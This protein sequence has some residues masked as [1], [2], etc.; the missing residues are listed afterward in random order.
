MS[1]F[2]LFSKRLTLYLQNAFIVSSEFS[3]KQQTLRSST[4]NKIILAL[5]VLVTSVFLFGCSENQTHSQKEKDTGKW[6]SEEM[7]NFRDTYN[8]TTYIYESKNEKLVFIG[9]G[10]GFGISNKSQISFENKTFGKEVI[11]KKELNEGKMIL[12]KNPE[13]GIVEPQSFEKDFI[14]L[15]FKI[16]R[17]KSPKKKGGKK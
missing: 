15:T 14:V 17:Q 4:V 3:L 16:D 13:K 9:E 8:G 11:L 2:L 1:L 10:I 6:S 5:I 7:L 12:M